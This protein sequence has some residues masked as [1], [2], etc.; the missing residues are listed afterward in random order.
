MVDLGLNTLWH[1]E[2]RVEEGRG[3]AS[4]ASGPHHEP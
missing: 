2:K 3:P 4:I 1:G